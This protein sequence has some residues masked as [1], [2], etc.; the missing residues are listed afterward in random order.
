MN[1]NSSDTHRITM[2]NQ[3]SP[4]DRRICGGFRYLNRSEQQVLFRSALQCALILVCLT[5]AA[6]A[7]PQTITVQMDKPGAPL[8]PNQFGIFFEDI[9]FGADGGLYPERIKNRSFEFTDPLMGWKK[10][11]LSGAKG[12]VAILDQEPLNPNTAHFL[13]LKLE[14]P[15][16]GFGISNEGFKGIGVQKGSLYN[17]SVYARSGDGTAVTM[18]IELVNAAGQKLGQAKLGAFTKEWRKHM[19]QFRATATEAQATLNLVLEGRGI[20][21]LDMVS[22]FPKETWGNRPNGLRPDLVQFL[23]DMKPGFIRFPGGCIVEGRVL[24]TRYQWKKT[25]GDLQDRK[26]II[27]R[28]NDE[29][30]H[31]PAPDYFQTF[32]LGFYEYFQ[33]CEDVGAEA[34]PILNCGM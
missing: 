24:E 2:R 17:F 22:L 1:Q 33:L 30:K 12:S 20:L 31:R 16:G 15:G 9:N 18:R 34:L 21:D 11:E 13:R 4:V 27:N 5:I 25:I 29:F 19:T 10:I 26:L 8:N 32:G 3:R 14:T 7:Q 23:K 6:Y 28:W